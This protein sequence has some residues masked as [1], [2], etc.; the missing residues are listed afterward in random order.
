MSE[1]QTKDRK[2]LLAA[3][4]QAK[5]KPHSQA[6]ERKLGKQK[7]GAKFDKVNFNG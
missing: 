3:V 7:N 6:L 2:A 4:R 5:R 1:K